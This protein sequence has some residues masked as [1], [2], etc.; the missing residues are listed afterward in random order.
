M[1]RSGR[2]GRAVAAR[3]GCRAACAAHIPRPRALCPL[4]LCRTA[5][6]GALGYRRDCRRRRFGR[7]KRPYKARIAPLLAPLYVRR[8]GSLDGR[9]HRLRRLD[10]ARRQQADLRL[11]ST[12]RLHLRPHHSRR[13]AQGAGR[14]GLCRSYS[15]DTRR[16]RLDDIGRYRFGRR[17]TPS[18]GI[19]CRTVFANR[20]RHPMPYSRATSI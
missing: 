11:P 18:R 10:N 13:S 8:H 19:W 15:Q 1:A 20:S 9:I 2:S 17:S 14:V 5:G 4:A 3:G 7:D 12:L 6:R 16:R